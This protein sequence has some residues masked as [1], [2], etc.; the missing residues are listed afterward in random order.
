MKRKHGNT[1]NIR[2][3][4][5]ERNF[6]HGEHGTKFYRIWKSMKNRCTN[7]NSPK[8]K[9]YGGRGI[10]IDS[11]WND[12]VGFKADMYFKFLYAKKWQYRTEDLS[13]E[14]INVN[15]NYC[16]DN[17]IFIPMRDQ[18]KNKQKEF[19]WFKITTPIG[20]VIF[21]KNLNQFA[22]DHNLNYSHCYSCV[23]GN[24]RHHKGFKFERITNF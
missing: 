8:W 19:S 13:I 10:T 7:P 15:G 1:G 6:K 22:K 5:S 11:R 12:F 21:R 17:C 24:R 23:S 14:R 2:P 9:N 4:L 3:D 18:W 20:G 16:F